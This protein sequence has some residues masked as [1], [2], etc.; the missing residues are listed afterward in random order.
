MF[1]TRKLTALLLAAALMLSLLAGCGKEPAPEAAETVPPE[2]TA[3]AFALPEELAAALSRAVILLTDSENGHAGG[4]KA[5]LADAAPRLLGGELYIPAAFVA[6]GLGGTASQEEGK[7]TVAWGGN[8][9]EIRSDTEQILLNG[10]EQSFAS[11]AAFTEEG[12]LVP[13]EEYCEMLGAE[14][15]CREDLV[16]IGQGLEAGFHN[17][18]SQTLSLVCSAMKTNLAGSLPKLEGAT[19][20]ER[21]KHAFV[22]NLDPEN[23]PFA[24]AQDTLV[25]VTGSLYVDNLSVEY[26]EEKDSFQVK[27]TVYNYLGYCY[28]SVEVYDRNDRLVELERVKPYEGMKASA[29]GAVADMAKV[30]FD[31]A[32]ALAYWDA[33]YLTY[34]TDLNSSV[35]EITVEVPRDGYIFITCNPAYSE[36]VALSDMVYALVHTTISLS[37]LSEVV[38][39]EKVNGAETVDRLVEFIVEQLQKDPGLLMEMKTEFARIFGN[40]EYDFLNLGNAAG[41]VAKAVLESFD[42]MEIP[43]W[44]ILSEALEFLIADPLSEDGEQLLLDTFLKKVSELAPVAN[45]ALD[46]WKISTTAGNMVSCFMDLSS[47]TGCGALILEIS[48]WREAYAREL[49][50][51]IGSGDRYTLAY[52]NGDNTPELLVLHA[53]GRIGSYARI[54]SYMCRQVVPIPTEYGY[55]MQMGYGEMMYLPYQGTLIQGNSYNGVAFIDVLLLEEDGFRVNTTFEDN[56]MQVSERGWVSYKIDGSTVTKARYFL[57]LTE[58]GIFPEDAVLSE[59]WPIPIDCVTERATTISAHNSGWPISHDG[60]R[61]IFLFGK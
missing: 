46:A 37:E 31:T 16:F 58:L 13:A 51:M 20:A 38:F 14:L 56:A 23:C 36:Y 21:A 2:D 11:G 43:I 25:A 57:G 52:L 28:G 22:L 30:C 40:R 17:A 15:S 26:L 3:K 32:E 27:M 7:L 54:Y 42:R 47:V 24:T 9:L 18:D 39:G 41:E 1:M 6:R 60:I 10:T 34:R 53:E 50:P 4:V 12:V 49:E 45:K 35:N 61:A 29:I 44:D 5:A 33:Q 19:F 55:D 8:T 48:D 59:K